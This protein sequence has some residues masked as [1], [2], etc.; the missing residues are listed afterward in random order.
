FFPGALVSSVCLA[1]YSGAMLSDWL[2]PY[3]PYTGWAVYAV[4]VAGLSLL[5]GR[6]YRLKRRWANPFRQVL[7]QCAPGC[8]PAASR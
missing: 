4:A 7:A 3:G 5:T 8:L 2:A 1:V 6:Y